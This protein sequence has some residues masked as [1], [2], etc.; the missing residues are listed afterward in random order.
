MQRVAVI[1][2]GI[3]MTTGIGMGFLA[4]LNGRS[5]ELIGPLATGLVINVI[6]GMVAGVVLIV[7]GNNLPNLNMQTAKVAAPVMIVSGVLGIGTLTGISFSVGKIGTAAGVA[8]II[9]GQML[10][11][12]VL[13]TLGLGRLESIPLSPI[14]LTGVVLMLVATWLLLPNEHP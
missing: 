5:G 6:A 9:A 8:A 10:T 7:I 4:A 13:D 12:T 14:R 11:A 3:A 1:A 2:L